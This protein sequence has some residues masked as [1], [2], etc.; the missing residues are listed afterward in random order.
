MGG[1]PIILH[2]CLFPS[3]HLTYVTCPRGLRVE[4]S[5][6]NR[7]QGIVK[8][9]TQTSLPPQLGIE[10]ITG[11]QGQEGG[12][13]CRVSCDQARGSE[14]SGPFLFLVGNS[15]SNPSLVPGECC[16]LSSAK[17]PNSNPRLGLDKLLFK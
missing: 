13:L 3:D 8:G 7:L 5:R 14:C 16:L 9:P 1:Q 10:T 4:V 15:P 2:I 12:V 17:V 6:G 11:S